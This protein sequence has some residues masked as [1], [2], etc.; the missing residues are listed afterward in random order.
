M[1]YLILIPVFCIFTFAGTGM[2]SESNGPAVPS[3]SDTLELVIMSTTDVHGWVMPWDYYADSPEERY[4]LAKAAT[5]IDSIRNVHDYTIVLDNGD[6]LQ[7]NPFA[8]YFATVDT[9]VPYPFLEIIDYLEYDAIVLGNHEFD[10]GLDL[11]DLR[12]HQT[13]TPVLGANMY[14]HGATD[15]A[16]TPY[17]IKDINDLSVGI[18]GLNTPG[19]AVWNRPR[20]EGR[21][22]F[23]DGVVAAGR[24]VPE[25]IEKGADI[26]IALAHTGFDR[27]SSYGPEGVGEENF[28]RALAES[29][30]GIDHIVLGHAH[31]LIGDTDITGPDGRTVGVIM[32]GRWSS[33]VGVS[34]LTI[35][36]DPDHERW[37]VIDQ[38]TETLPVEQVSP[39][40]GVTTRVVRAHETVRA[41]VNQPVAATSVTW[42]ADRARAED[43]PIIDLIQHVQMEVTGARLSAAAAFNPRVRL[44]PGTIT[45][46]QIAQLYPYENTLYVLELSGK[47]VREY[48][49]YTSRYYLQP[50]E[51]HP[52]AV[53]PEWPGFNFDM[54]AGVEY[55]LDLRN[56]PGER[57]VELHYN[58]EPVSG[59]DLF[60]MAVNSY[61]AVGG[62]GFDMLKD[63]RVVGQI[64]RSVRELIIEYLREKGEIHPDDVF[65]R[66]WRLIPSP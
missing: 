4:G 37:R 35:A 51:G 42:S 30:P 50:E 61:R 2:D 3:P 23:I 56:P 22:D 46:A 45:L 34:T 58:G 15:P 39:H 47:Q 49:E 40:E 6:W 31:R 26:V 14:R 28:G 5:I 8:E 59:N 54:L 33:H 60:T 52:P 1:K 43:T 11:L 25:L 27:E 19:T 57:V 20:L 9:T 63:A 16:F 32:P 41:Y 62:G 64:D 10:F 36:Y 29:V 21:I 24:F 12:I 38:Q 55:V 7:G 66:N 13:E 48:L 44:G 53:D 17:I 65:T 18:L